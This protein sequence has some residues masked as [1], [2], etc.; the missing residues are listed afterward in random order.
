MLLLSTYQIF[1]PTYFHTAQEN[2]LKQLKDKIL[3]VD[4]FQVLQEDIHRSS[5]LIILVKTLLNSLESAANTSLLVFLVECVPLLEQ[6]SQL[7]FDKQHLVEELKERWRLRQ[8]HFDEYI[9]T[10]LE[11]LSFDL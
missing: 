5:S 1:N 10:K 11:S 3:N 6:I 4:L 9:T 7:F 8:H 2:L